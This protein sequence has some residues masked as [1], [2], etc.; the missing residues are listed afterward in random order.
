MLE[1]LPQETKDTIVEYWGRGYSRR[2]IAIALCLDKKRVER[3]LRHHLMTEEEREVRR[4]KRADA[5][6]IKAKRIIVE[7][8]DGTRHLVYDP[9]PAH[10]LAER[11]RAFS[12][13]FSIEIDILGSPPPGRSA[14]EQ[15]REA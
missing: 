2:E 4:Q 7:H 11:D 1:R 8:D 12:R 9:P 15:M 13:E 10:V 6:R 14:L 5:K 3:F